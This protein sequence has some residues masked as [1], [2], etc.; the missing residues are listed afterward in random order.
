MPAVKAPKM[1]GSLVLSNVALGIFGLILT[2]V[3]V[4]QQYALDV[5]PGV[6]TAVVLIVTT[7][8][9]LGATRADAARLGKLIP[10]GIALVLTTLASIGQAVVGL[11]DVSQDARAVVAGA[12]VLIMALGIQPTSPVTPVPPPQ[13]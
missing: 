12:L 1:A 11:S 2:A 8:A 13:R 10:H 4:I 6:H 9:A 5:R 3:A 7:L